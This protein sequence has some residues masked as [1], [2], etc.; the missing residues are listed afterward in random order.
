MRKILIIQTAFAGDMILTTPLLTEAARCHPGAEIDVLCIPATVGLLENH[1]AV[2]HCI[3]YDKREGKPSLTALMRLLHRASYD[4]CISPHRSL[5]SALLAWSTRAPRR[6]TFDRSTGA[7]LYTHRI[8]YDPH[9]H[10]VTR[11]LQLLAA[12]GCSPREFVAPS[13]HPDVEDC[14]AVDAILAA[15]A[16]RPYVCLAPGSVW[17]TKRWIEEGFAA[18]ARALSTTHVV[19]FIGGQGD[20]DLC[21]RIEGIAGIEAINTAGTLSLLASAACIGGAALLVSNDS[22]PVHMASAMGTP[23]VE[24]FGATVPEFGFTPY[25]VKHRIVQRE[26][27]ACKPCTIHGGQTCPIATF[28]CMRD[29]PASD[30]LAAA[31]ELLQ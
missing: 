23:V 22:A 24:I 19:V 30:V 8:R 25:G 11:N 6:V 7:E 17:A 9:V 15:A 1:P 31:H 18:V 21:T 4:L 14:S 16:G 5:R 29:L 26:G 28:A 2:S 12:A 27:L 20:R 10:E 13:L 3:I